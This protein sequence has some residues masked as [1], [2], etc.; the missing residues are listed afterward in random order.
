MNQASYFIGNSQF[1]L[2]SS[3][4][5]NLSCWNH[6]ERLLA[7]PGNIAQVNWDLGPDFANIGEANIV[8]IRD[9][10]NYLDLEASINVTVWAADD[11]NYTVNFV[12]QQMTVTPADLVGSEN[13][14]W[15]APLDETIFDMSRRYW[16]V[17]IVTPNP[18]NPFVGA[19][20]LS[21]AVRLKR[22]PVYPF[23]IALNDTVAQSRKNHIEI[24]AELQGLIGSEKREL[25]DRVFSYA[26]LGPIFIYDPLDVMLFGYKL[27]FFAVD[28]PI[29]R[30]SQSGASYNITLSLEEIL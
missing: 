23:R 5:P 7:A 2:C 18:H 6:C 28:I 12:Q 11:P 1:N 17:R 16:R 26:D 20:Y 3:Q 29:A 15:V 25:E 9:F 22:N 13:K 27:M 24:R 19:I 30:I 4:V 10:K 8:A 14:D 21:N